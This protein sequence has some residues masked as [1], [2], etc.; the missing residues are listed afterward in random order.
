MR[1]IVYISGALFS[2]IAIL[3]ILFK[4]LHLQGAQILLII[5]IGGLALIFVPVYALY[6]YNKKKNNG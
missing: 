5:G 2:S 1:K 4:L 3:S 6:R